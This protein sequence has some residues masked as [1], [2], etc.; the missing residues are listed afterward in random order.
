VRGRR[1]YDY[2]IQIAYEYLIKSGLARVILN[3]NRDEEVII[4]YHKIKAH[5]GSANPKKN[6]NYYRYAKYYIELI[7]S[8]VDEEPSGIELR[9]KHILLDERAKQNF[10]KGWK[11]AE[12]RY[13][14]LV[15]NS[16]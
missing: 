9:S 2:E 12:K 6:P 10:K 7:I 16:F 1:T 5:K 8:L 14:D 15:K 3:H 11:I 4:P 13:E